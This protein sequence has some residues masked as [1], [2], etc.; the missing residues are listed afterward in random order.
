MT[1]NTWSKTTAYYLVILENKDRVISSD[2]WTDLHTKGYLSPTDRD[3]DY[4]WLS[5]TNVHFIKSH[6]VLHCYCNF[7][8][9][10]RFLPRHTIHFKLA[11]VSSAYS[12]FHEIPATQ[13]SKWH[14][15]MWSNHSPLN[16]L[17]RSHRGKIKNHPNSL[18]VLMIEF[19]AK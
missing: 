15:T 8:R 2:T 4:F 12:I 9:T 19:I 10:D 6:S 17:L 13:H 14:V 1:E 16:P 7:G 18:S 5:I 11:R 3:F